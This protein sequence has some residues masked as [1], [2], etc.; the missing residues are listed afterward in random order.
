MITILENSPLKYTGSTSNPQ[1]YL[2]NDVDFESKL[3]FTSTVNT[4]FYTIFRVDPTETICI[5][6]GKLSGHYNDVSY[7]Y[8]FDFNNYIT[9]Y[10]QVTPVLEYIQAPISSGFTY[11]PPMYYFKGNNSTKLYFLLS[12]VEIVNS[13]ITYMLLTKKAN[14]EVILANDVSID[15]VVATDRLYFQFWDKKTNN[16]IIKYTTDNEAV[17][18]E[19][20]VLTVYKYPLMELDDIIFRIYREYNNVNYQFYQ[21]DPENYD[22]VTYLIQLPEDLVNFMIIAKPGINAIKP[23][24][25]IN[26]GCYNKYYYMSDNGAF[27]CIKCTGTMNEVNSVTRKNYQLGNKLIQTR[28]DVIKQIRQ[29]TGFNL[30]ENQIYS[31]INSPNVYTIDNSNNVKEYVVDTN[32]FDG[33]RNIKLSG[34]NIELVLT[35]PKQYRQKTNYE[36]N[37]FD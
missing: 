8:R 33:Y 37:F 34:R 31:L 35:D 4:L 12:N 26:P 28:I 5:A 27:D 16:D 18:S 11:G 24:I 20:Y 19:K 22:Y 15:E 36:I 3:Y 23:K 29:N 25:V 2:I 17:A 30:N 14:G 13:N 6:A 7:D 32:S 10:N 9:I 21:I 1:K